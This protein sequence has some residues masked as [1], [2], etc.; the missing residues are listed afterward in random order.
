MLKMIK[1]KDIMSEGSHGTSDP[2]VAAKVCT[3][4]KV[5]NQFKT[6]SRTPNP[7]W[8]PNRPVVYVH[9]SVIPED[10]AKKDPDNVLS[11]EG[12]EI[13]SANVSMG[14]KVVAIPL[15]VK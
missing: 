15:V 13:S 14:Q 10:A 1:G 11:V 9:C 12:A 5:I 3:I 6:M 7:D 2:N 4:K 8:G